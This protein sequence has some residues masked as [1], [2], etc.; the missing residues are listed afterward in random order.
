MIFWFTLLI[1]SVILISG[2]SDAAGA[3]TACV[4][5]RSMPEEKALRLAAVSTFVGSVVM[6]LLNP[7]IAKTFFGVVDLGDDPAR[8]MTALCA[9]LSAAVLWSGTA[10]ALGLPTSESH[11]LVSGMS[12]AAVAVTGRLDAIHGHEWLRILL[13]LAISMLGPFFLGFLCNRILHALLAGQNRRRTLSYFQRSQRFSASWNAALTGAQDCQKFMGVYLLG[14]SMLGGSMGDRSSV[15]LSILILSAAV[16][17]MGTLLGSTHVIKKV[18][19]DMAALD[20][21]AYSAAGAAS[22]AVMTLCT[23]FGIPASITHTRA[24]AFVGA[25]MNRKH[26]VD[27]RVVLQILTAWLLTLPVCAILGFVLCRGLLVLAL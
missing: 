2:W 9:S 12:G 18:G 16:M 10:R 22:T 3:V 20:A 4:S 8:A 15:P 24:S 1:L 13:G 14:L 25:G 5:V 19:K 23:C 6:T 26:S 17:A 11:A 21:P 7:S 27:F